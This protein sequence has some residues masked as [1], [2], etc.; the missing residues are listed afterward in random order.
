MDAYW[1]FAADRHAMWLARVD[2]SESPPDDPILRTYRFTNAYRV[3]DRVSQYL[4]REV[5]HRHDQSP[6]EVVLRTLLFKLFNKIETWELICSAGVPSVSTF[7]PAALSALLGDAQRRG[8]A[9]Y[10]AAY[11]VPPVALCPSPKHRGH[12]ALIARMLDDDLADRARRAGGLADLYRLLRCY[13]GIGPF[14]AFQLAIDLNYSSAVD[15]D[16]AEYVVAGPGALDGISKCLPGT[17]PSQA[18]RVIHEV[19]DRQEEEFAKRGIEF[20]GL[21]GR[22]LQPIDCQNLFCEISKYSRVAFPG[23]AGSAG[24]TRIKQRYVPAGALP[25]PFF[26]PKW[27]LQAPGEGSGFDGQGDARRTAPTARPAERSYL[28]VTA[29]LF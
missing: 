21:F 3:C 1:Q 25:R 17:P 19:C 7:D 27:Q 11:I 22:R 12:L 15:F 28:P 24:R 29:L 2:G 10:S 5:Q 8:Q 23:V 26:P 4:V 20:P 16:E 6:S 18:Q 14:L 13:P 9:V